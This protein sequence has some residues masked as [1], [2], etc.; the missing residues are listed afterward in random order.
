MMRNL[1]NKLLL[2]LL[3]LSMLSLDACRKGNNGPSWDVDVLAPIL[4]TSLGVKNLV[5]DSLIQTNPDS[6]L[7]IVFDN[8]I[9]RLSL[10]TLVSLPDTSIKE[11][12]DLPFGSFY[13][14]P[15]QGI[16]TLNNLTN[17]TKY[18]LKTVELTEARIR[19]GFVS[20]ELS[21]SIPEMTVVSYSMPGFIKQGVPFS[22][23]TQVPAGSI[24]NPATA[25]VKFNLTGYDVDL[26]GT[27]GN[28]F[29]TILANISVIIDVA[30]PDSV[31]ITAGDFFEIKYN[32]EDIITDYAK[33]Y[34]GQY[35]ISINQQIDTL[36]FFNNVTSGFL[37]L[38][39][40]DMQ[41]SIENGFGMDAQIV[42]DTL[43]A[44][45]SSTGTDVLL[46]HAFIGT[47]INLTRASQVPSPGY[48]FTYSKYDLNINSTN[49]NV[50]EFI[51]NFPDLL[52]H[53][54][55]IAINPWG[56]NSNGNDFFY[57][58]SDFKVSLKL[59][60]PVSFSANALTIQDTVLFSAAPSENG[61]ENNIVGGFLHLDVNNGFPYEA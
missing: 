17:E 2:A 30:A 48:R 9:F 37:D 16:P 18:N 19:S 42:I 13:L 15:G 34:F 29:N 1:I 53:S 60:L 54:Y 41:L 5:P 10:D 4:K 11:R 58:E 20:F 31:P 51:E 35:N 39:S 56:N 49:S 21:S 59:Q 26:K 38:E 3:A 27:F 47:S 23:S 6:S 45:N 36:D 44:I 32:L 14:Q 8:T 52:G 12:F 24:S 46:N 28:D 22:V 33:G 40:I 57:F 50:A 25:Y 43:N 61:T 55:D 7:T